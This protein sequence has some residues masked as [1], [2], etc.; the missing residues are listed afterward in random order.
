M[1]RWSFEDSHLHVEGTVFR[2]TQQTQRVDQERKERSER[3]GKA[4]LFERKRRASF[5]PWAGPK[6]KGTSIEGTLPTG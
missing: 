3:R 5:G 1:G 4:H 2:L 6:F